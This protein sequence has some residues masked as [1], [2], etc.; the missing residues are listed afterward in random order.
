M[1]SKPCKT[2]VLVNALSTLCNHRISTCF[3]QRGAAIQTGKTQAWRTLSGTRRTTLPLARP[4]ISAQ[5]EAEDNQLIKDRL[6]VLLFAKPFRDLVPECGPLNG[7]KWRLA[8][9]D[10]KSRR[11]DAQAGLDTQSLSSTQMFIPELHRLAQG[12]NQE[13]YLEGGESCRSGNHA[14][15]LVRGTG[16]KCCP[17]T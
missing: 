4:R 7:V 17:T 11:A 13:K 3:A 12:E 2:I 5:A 16:Y 8:E 10:A 9:L 15:G 14:N 1:S 6:E